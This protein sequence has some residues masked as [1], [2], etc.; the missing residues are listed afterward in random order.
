MPP[1]LAARGVSQRGGA[2][3]RGSAALAW[4]QASDRRPH[5][6][7]SL[8]GAPKGADPAQARSD[9]LLV[10]QGFDGVEARSLHGGIEAEE[11]ADRER[12]DQADQDCPGGGLGRE[13]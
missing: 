1:V 6:A 11:D 4:N 2:S 10:A 13:R 12:D 3:R 7:E 8:A 5:P 9:V